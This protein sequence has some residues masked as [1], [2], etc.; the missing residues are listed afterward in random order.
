MKN[1]TSGKSSTFGQHVTKASK[2]VQKIVTAS[3]G[4]HSFS[5]VCIFANLAHIVFLTSL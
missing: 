1:L 2:G 4:A 3:G 5:D